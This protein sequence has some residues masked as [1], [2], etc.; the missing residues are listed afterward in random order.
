MN[1][2]GPA[3]AAL[4][5][6]VTAA[7]VA[8]ALRGGDPSPVA[9]TAAGAAAAVGTAALL[10]AGWRPRSLGSLRSG[11]MLLLGLPAAV[12]ALGGGSTG[13]LALVLT[14]VAAGEVAAASRPGVRE[15]PE[16]VMAEGRLGWARWAPAD[17]H[18]LAPVGGCLLVAGS[19]V[20]ERA[21]SARWVPPV[22]HTVP[23]VLALAGA[24]LL[25][26]A[27]A[28]GPRRAWSLAIPA[29]V[30]ALPAAGD[31]PSGAAALAGALA[32]TAGFAA[33]HRPT[34]ALAALAVAAAPLAAV[35][36]VAPLLAAA[37]VLALAFEHPAA[38]ALGLPGAAVL[39]ALVVP[40]GR[41]GSA[42]V[43]AAAATA[44]ALALADR[45]AAALR[46]APPAGGPASH[47]L[48]PAPLP[49]WRPGPDAAPVVV[50]GAWLLFAPGT[51]TWTGVG[52]TGPYDRGAAVA[53]ASGSLA[54]LA[55]AVVKL[56]RP[57]SDQSGRADRADP[58]DPPGRADRGRG[59]DPAAP[60]GPV[61]V[62]A[63]LRRRARPGTA[64]RPGTGADS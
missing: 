25:V 14:L 22:G 53:V 33:A 15:R 39:A 37:A 40:S 13:L 17:R 30:V 62:P 38:A 29:L 32:V 52:G 27:A 23:V 41:S 45:A 36:P 60:E 34:L 56:R 47:A 1:R 26:L 21:A 42:V 49:A 11:G 57:G 31:L 7:W 48:A 63:P 18:V 28:L 61:V 20:A 59:A 35:A 9:T 12:A 46:P 51:W 55:A 6:V 50:L 54:L 5:A 10:G 58:F 2:V 8:V 43:V 3:W 64:P 44:T 24:A 19:L 16:R 4:S